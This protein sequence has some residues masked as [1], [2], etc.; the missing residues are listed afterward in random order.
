MNPY[1]VFVTHVDGYSQFL[2]TIQ[3]KSPAQAQNAV[4]QS[5]DKERGPIDD[6]D[7]Y[8]VTVLDPVFTS[9]PVQICR[10]DREV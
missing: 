8:R 5:Y 1:I 4:W 3:A 2:Y 10:V 7:D 9:Q 6:P